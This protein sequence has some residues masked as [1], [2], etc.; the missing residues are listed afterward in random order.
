MMAVLEENRDLV[1]VGAYRKGV[2]P[3]LDFAL[4]RAEELN[5]LL[6]SGISHRSLAETL[7]LMRGLRRRA[8]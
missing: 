8:G 5:R 2:D 1:Q 6:H 4:S 7:A 3:L